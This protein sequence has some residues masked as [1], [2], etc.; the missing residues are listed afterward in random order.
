MLLAERGGVSTP[1]RDAN[2]AF[3]GTDHQQLV[4]A[5]SPS[6]FL[7]ACSVC[8]NAYKHLPS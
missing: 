5:A 3:G 6:V 7:I 2:P 8:L 1:E 4:I